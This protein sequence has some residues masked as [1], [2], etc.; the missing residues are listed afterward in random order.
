MTA[1]T[2]APSAQLVTYRQPRRR[3]SELTL[4][5]LA[6]AVAAFGYVQVDLAVLGHLSSSTIPVLAVAA[7]L[8]IGAHIA[9]WLLAPYSD[10]VILP[11]AVALNLLG[12]MMIHRLDLADLQRA[13]RN[14]TAL[15]RPQITDQ[16]LWTALGIFLFVAVLFVVRDHRRLQRFTYTSL[17]VGVLLLLLPLAPIIGKSVRGAT[18]WIRIGGYSFQPGELAKV[19]L[20]I[21]F[22]GYLVVKRDSLALVRTKVL[23]MSFP[24]GR[25]L[26]PL[27][28]AWFASLAI[29]IFETD[30]GSS[31]LF[32][33]LAVSLLYVATQRRS[34]LVLGAVLFLSGAVMAYLAFGHVR[35]RFDLWLHPFAD[36]SGAG[37]QLVQS[38]YGFA[39]GGV[40]GSGLG[41]GYPQFVPFASSDFI[42][43]AF[44]E[45]IGLAG[46]VA[47]LML[48]AILVERGLRAGIACR[49]P[50]GTLLAAGLA[51]VTALQVF[52]V[53]GGVTRLIPL[54]GLT[55]PFLSQGGSS[56]IANWVVVALLVRITNTTRRPDPTVSTGDAPTQVVQL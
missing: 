54:T 34:W 27:L 35:V 19:F 9:V 31:L 29:L 38:L 48:Y 2:T 30:L 51:I 43:A 53:A 3:W 36:A 49:D 15:P 10:P 46:L 6:F 25:D 14:G 52:I 7:G 24:R 55:T 44:G 28:V 37:Y 16:L 39:S 21:F 33:G 8:V 18:L 56:L 23:G 50:F 41:Q 4:L 32:F 11:V 22:A 20:T 5:V 42:V 26:G 45:E 47:M 1:T 13:Q 12:L 40:F 17:L